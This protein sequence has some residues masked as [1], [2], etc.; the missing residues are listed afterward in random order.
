MDE[1]LCMLI[2]FPSMALSV[3]MVRILLAVASRI[4]RERDIPRNEP[5]T[6]VPRLHKGW[7]G[8]SLLSLLG[9][10]VGIP[11]SIWFTLQIWDRLH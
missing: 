9:A 6:V 7:I 8:A 1:H 4:A 5:P 3:G 11:A 2:A 10:L